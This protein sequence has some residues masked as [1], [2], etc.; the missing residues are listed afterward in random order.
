MTNTEILNRLKSLLA[1]VFG[2]RLHGVVLYGSEAR[3]Q[4]QPDSDLDVLVLLE[5]PVKLWDDLGAAIHATYP[6][7]LELGGRP[8][9]IKPVDAA[10]YEAQEWPL[11]RQAKR[12]GL[13]A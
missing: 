1:E 12:E 4:A 3:G 5:G 10:K 11:Y 9:D 8:I 2:E 6:L 13:V 7:V